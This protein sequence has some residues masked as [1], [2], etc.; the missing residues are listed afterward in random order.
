VLWFQSGKGPQ[1][2]VKSEVVQHEAIRLTPIRG[3]GAGQEGRKILAGEKNVLWGRDGRTKRRAPF[4]H[5][6]AKL[7]KLVEKKT[8]CP[9]ALKE[10]KP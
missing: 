9:G 8:S 1:E 2:K 3:G 4:E 6:G 5:W 10:E 7:V